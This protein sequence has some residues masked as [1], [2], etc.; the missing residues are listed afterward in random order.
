MKKIVVTLVL[1]LSSIVGNTEAGAILLDSER[2]FEFIQ[3]DYI[4]TNYL[5]DSADIQLLNYGFWFD[6]G[7]SNPIEYK[8]HQVGFD[9]N[10]QVWKQPKWEDGILWK[11]SGRPTAPLDNGDQTFDIW[12]KYQIDDVIYKRGLTDIA[13]QAATFDYETNI[14]SIFMN[15]EVD[16]FDGIL[17]FS[18][19]QFYGD[20]NVVPHTS[21][22]APVD[23]PE[24]SILALFS[25]V[26]GGFLTKKRITK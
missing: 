18:N 8:L 10:S 1:V 15:S 7:Y 26:L 23:V 9:K 21:K 25:L 16:G 4:D 22:L 13:R 24:P 19:I 3:D 6:A 20:E 11:E 17:T 14:M 2:Q 5:V 12:Y